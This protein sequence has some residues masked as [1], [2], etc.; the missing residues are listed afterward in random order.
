VNA[1]AA[2]LWRCMH[3][4]HGTLGLCV[5]LGCLSARVCVCRR[6]AIV[7]S[8]RLELGSGQVI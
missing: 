8:L 7:I 6:A 2:A 3:W 4:S 5:L 1:A